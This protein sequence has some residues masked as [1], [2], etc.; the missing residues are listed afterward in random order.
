MGRIRGAVAVLASMLVLGALTAASASASG[1]D[2][3][4]CGKRSRR[5]RGPTRTRP[6]RSNRRGTKASTN[7]STGSA[8]AKGSRARPA[9]GDPILRA[10]ITPGEVNLKCDKASISG[11]PV[12]PNK[13]AGVH[14]TKSKCEYNI[15][16]TDA[17]SFSTTSLSGKLGW[18][19]QGKGEAGIKLTSEAEPETGLITEVQNSCLPEGNSACA[20]RDRRLESRRA[21]DQGTLARLLD[22][23]MGRR[24]RPHLADQPAGLRRRRRGTHPAQ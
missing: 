19:N 2:W 9:F 7:C 4:Y 15:S 3:A 8:K 1:P 20:A 16:A 23:R 13:V 18:M 21:A 17:C 10:M 24:R 6:A 11:H 22:R 12:A 14:I 5:T